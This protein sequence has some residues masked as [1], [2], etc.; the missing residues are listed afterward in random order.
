[1]KAKTISLLITGDDN[2]RL[3]PALILGLLVSVAGCSGSSSSGTSGGNGTIVVPLVGFWYGSWSRNTTLTNLIN[4]TDDPTTQ[5]DPEDGVA[6]LQ[7]TSASGSSQTIS[8]ELLMSG[9]SCFDTGRVSGSW[10]GSNIGM[11]AVSGS[12]LVSTSGISTTVTVVSGGS[13]YTSRPT[14]TF[15]APEVSTGTTATGTA[16][17]G[18]TVTNI[19]VAKAGSGYEIAPIISITG[20]GGSGALATAALESTVTTEGT[21]IRLSLAGH[22]TAGGQIK[23]AYSVASGS[24]CDAKR[25]SITLSK[26]G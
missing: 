3:F 18:D 23:L 10:F 24:T 16:V 13:G 6:R 2:R 26:S 17:R 15:S 22:Q 21:G 1:M 4:D 12:T 5:L 9:F 14:V 19:I 25:G 8:G 20:G 7:I 11:T